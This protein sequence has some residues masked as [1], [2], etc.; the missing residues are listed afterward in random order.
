MTCGG[1]TGKEAFIG[2]TAT[3]TIAGKSY[4]CGIDDETFVACTA[5]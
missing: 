1:N 4:G 3:A 2:V 5:Q